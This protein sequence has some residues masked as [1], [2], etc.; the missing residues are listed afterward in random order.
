[1]LYIVTEESIPGSSARF[2]VQERSQSEGEGAWVFW[3]QLL[4]LEVI[5]FALAVYKAYQTYREMDTTSGAILPKTLHV[6]VR[7][8]TLYFLA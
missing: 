3:A 7:D 8:S 2:C 5:L 1:M 6:L 4:A